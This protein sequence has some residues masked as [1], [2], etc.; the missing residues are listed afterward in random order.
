MIVDR[1]VTGVKGVFLNPP[2]REGERLFFYNGGDQP[3]F[4]PKPPRVEQRTANS[5]H[6]RQS[7][8]QAGWAKAGGRRTMDDGQLHARQ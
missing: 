1:G 4:Q 3:P 7:V 5:A 8:T 2:S 6:T